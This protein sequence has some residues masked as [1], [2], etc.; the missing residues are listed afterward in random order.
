VPPSTLPTPIT[1]GS[2]AREGSEADGPREPLPRAADARLRS[3]AD[4]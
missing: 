2:D 1:Q 3:E 4:R